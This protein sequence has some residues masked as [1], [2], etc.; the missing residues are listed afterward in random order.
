MNLNNIYS[1]I[2]MENS[3]YQENKKE[4]EHDFSEKGYNASC[5][6]EIE[7]FLKVGK[8][9]KIDN[10]SFLGSGC[11]ISQASTNLLCNV[12]NKKS[13]KEA[14]EILKIYNNMLHLKELKEDEILKI[15]DL[16]ALKNIAMMP[17][18]IKC[19]CLCEVVAEK[20]IHEEK[21]I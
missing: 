17:S 13:I 11:A 21:D 20:M 2:I 3:I 16:I 8:D 9:K 12:L 1:D 4:I 18:R 5:G 10:I 14:K 6:D 19:A 7:I 15:G